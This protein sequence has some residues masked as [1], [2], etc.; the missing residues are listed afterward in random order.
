MLTISYLWTASM[1]PSPDLM[2]QDT[3][4]SQ[5]GVIATLTSTFLNLPEHAGQPSLSI[6]L[7]M[8]TSSSSSI[9]K[10]IKGI[11][12]WFL[13]F[14]CQIES[15]S[16]KTF[17]GPNAE[18]CSE[19]ASATDKEMKSREREKLLSY[20]MIQEKGGKYLDFYNIS[21]HTPSCQEILY[22][23]CTIYNWI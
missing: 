19:E 13:C 5:E 9:F 12:S 6:T 20:L 3:A 17:F 10:E 4:P 15:S 8:N 22:S 21:E 7:T 23:C 18:L 2:P 11:G 1:M 16:F 14:E